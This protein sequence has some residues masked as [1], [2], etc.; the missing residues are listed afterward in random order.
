[1]PEYVR[2]PSAMITFRTP[3]TNTLLAVMLAGTISLGV[4]ALPQAAAT[5]GLVPYVSQ[6]PVNLVPTN[7]L[8]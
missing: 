3:F 8:L 6:M 4:L 1:M 7:S 5:L 2:A